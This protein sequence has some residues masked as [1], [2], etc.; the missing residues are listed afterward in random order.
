MN[1]PWSDLKMGPGQGKGSDGLSGWMGG[2]DRP[3]E[4]QE[5]KPENKGQAE[6]F[7]DNKPI[8]PE[9]KKLSR[10]SIVKWAIFL[11]LIIYTLLS[12]YHAPILAR[13]GS[14]LVVEHPLEKADLIVCLAG[15][16]VERGLAA[17]EAYKRGLG[18]RI[19]ISR[20]VLPDGDEILR[21]RGLHYPESRDLM[22]MML[23]GL[24]VPASDCL[25][26]DRCVQSTYE[27]AKEVMDFTQKNAYRSVIIVTSPIH[28]RRAWLT[29]KKV[30]EKN[31]VKIMMLPS[32]YS[33]FRSDDWW[34][35]R[36]YLKAVAIEYQK[37][38]YYTLE[39]FL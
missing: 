14:Y 5:G 34:K 17:A 11:L 35:T 9:E 10:P 25:T 21:Q 16:P 6:Y 36:K 12:Y 13:V 2:Q 8:E 23:Q 31:E 1:M 39:Y 3:S 28:S 37:L 20:E 27:E 24:G 7:T 32:R 33:G 4:N 18:Q 19:F 30:F 29:F 22:K 26:S 38:A 15:C